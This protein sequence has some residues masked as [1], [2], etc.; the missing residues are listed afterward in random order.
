MLL[1]WISRTPVITMRSIRISTE[2]Y[3]FLLPI[4][5]IIITTMWRKIES[6]ALVRLIQILMQ[7]RRTTPLITIIKELI[8]VKKFK[9]Q[10]E[11]L[12]RL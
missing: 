7:S 8:I 10:G 5:S 9:V 1:S 3:L 4:M 2:G 12:A 11:M 6:S